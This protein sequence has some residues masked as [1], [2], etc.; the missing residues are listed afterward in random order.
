M[1]AVVVE[2]DPADA[3]YVKVDGVERVKILLMQEFKV[4][5]IDPTLGLR[6]NVAHDDYDG[7]PLFTLEGLV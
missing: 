5:K 7:Y 2:I 3:V 4:K 1:T 6:L